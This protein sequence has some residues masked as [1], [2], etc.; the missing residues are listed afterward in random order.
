L[1]CDWGFGIDKKG[2]EDKIQFHFVLGSNLW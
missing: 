1:G 2:Q